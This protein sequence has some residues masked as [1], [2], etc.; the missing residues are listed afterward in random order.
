MDLFALGTIGLLQILL[1]P[2]LAIVYLVVSRGLTRPKLRRGLWRKFW[3]FPLREGDAP[4]LW[5]HA[6]SVGEAQ[7]AE[8]LVDAFA[9]RHP[10]WDV[11]ISVSTFTGMEVARKRF[12]RR[13]VFYAP[14]DWSISVG[15]A[16]RR[17]RP[18]AIVLLELELWPVFLLSSRLRGIPVL[19]ANGR[20]T[21]RSCRRY[22]RGGPLSRF[23]FRRLHAAGV[24]NVEYAERFRRAGVPS[25][26]IEVLGNL[27]YDR[28]APA[29]AGDGSETRR[30]LGWPAEGGFTLLVAGCTHPGE[31]RLLCGLLP[32]WRAAEPGIRLILAPRHVE[33]LSGAE[34][35]SWESDRRLLRWSRLAE[36]SGGE[37][38][39]DVTVVVDTLGELER[40]YAAADLVFVG[41]S[42]V[43]HGGHNM[44]EATRLG[45]ATI[46]GPYHEN[47][48]D[49]AAYLLE[50]H[51][52]ECVRDA[53]ELE[54]RV[55]DLLRGPDRRRRLGDDARAL[56]G[57]LQGA[58][59]RHAGWIEAR[60]PAFFPR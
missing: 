41:G 53:E 59:E 4:C 52:V 32:A 17:L 16:L 24:Q 34:L 20:M 1:S 13:L 58:A 44:L 18:Q 40:F 7:L 6:V 15:R 42:L 25:E 47:F 30:R 11:V 26:R 49:E 23:L 5:V 12:P 57:R 27:K 21:E 39:G 56:T 33:R 2:L 28:R 43:P 19:V 14:V 31:E 37:L 48:R 45:K 51:A 8:P 35:A 29:E 50:G 46:F 54:E 38:G 55:L 10:E 36:A 3:G 22:E 60:I 9:S